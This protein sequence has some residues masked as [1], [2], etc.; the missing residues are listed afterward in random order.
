MLSKV[1]TAFL[2]L[3]AAASVIAWIAALC[4]EKG[5]RPFAGAVRFVRELPWGGR[6]ALLPLFM[7]LVVYGSTKYVGEVQG[8]V[9]GEGQGE[10]VGES[11]FGRVERVDRVD[12]CES[13]FLAQ[14]PQSSQSGDLDNVA[15]VEMFPITNTN[16]QLEIGTGNWQHSH[17]GNIERWGFCPWL[18]ADG[19]WHG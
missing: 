11:G 9:V 14:S 18:C 5:I 13:G 17:I 8:V 19:D 4:H 15:N 7:A 3:G 16:S 10:G 2:L 12:G 1:W 6:L